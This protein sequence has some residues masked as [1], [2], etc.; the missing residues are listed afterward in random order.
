MRKYDKGGIIVIHIRCLHKGTQYKSRTQST[1]VYQLFL[2]S[3]GAN[4]SQIDICDI[5]SGIFYQ[6]LSD[7]LNECSETV[8]QIADPTL[9]M[10]EELANARD[11]MEDPPQGVHFL[12]PVT[13]SHYRQPFMSPYISRRTFIPLVESPGMG[14]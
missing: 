10:V 7:M 13:R 6:A 8:S 11:M 4:N 12:F 5:I 3:P 14:S 1:Y 2:N 9:T